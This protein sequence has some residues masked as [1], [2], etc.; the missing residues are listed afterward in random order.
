[1]GMVEGRHRGRV[2]I[3]LVGN[4]EAVCWIARECDDLGPSPIAR[5]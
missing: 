2:N 1:L 3:P 4:E 5:L